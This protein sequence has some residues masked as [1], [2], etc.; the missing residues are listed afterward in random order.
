MFRR[1]GVQVAELRRLT[2]LLSFRAQVQGESRLTR[3]DIRLMT[4]FWYSCLLYSIEM[5]H[6]RAGF[7]LRRIVFTSPSCVS[8]PTDVAQSAQFNSTRLSPITSST[9]S[10]T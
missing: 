4:L 2:L 10:H 7:A 3:D 6:F 8:S 5:L 9:R 1:L